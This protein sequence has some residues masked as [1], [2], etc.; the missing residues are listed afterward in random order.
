MPIS[1]AH[2]WTFYDL[3]DDGTYEW[4]H[5]LLE[6]KGVSDDLTWLVSLA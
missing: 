5:G 1:E 4:N 2:N 3:G 6:K